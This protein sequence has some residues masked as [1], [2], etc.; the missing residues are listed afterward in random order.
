M[1]GS[2][3]FVARDSFRTCFDFESD[4]MNVIDRFRLINMSNARSVILTRG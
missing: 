1:S 2:A 3:C 4:S